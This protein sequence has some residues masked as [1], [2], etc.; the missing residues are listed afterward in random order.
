VIV[1]QPADL[2]AAVQGVSAVVS[3][4]HG[5]VGPGR[6]PASVDRD[7]NAN[8]IDAATTVGATTS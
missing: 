7:G 4:F 5:F 1:R 3:A 6:H 8:L 2:G